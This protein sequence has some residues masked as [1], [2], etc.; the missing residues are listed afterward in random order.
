TTPCGRRGPAQPGP[1]SGSRP[2]RPAG[3]RGWRSASCRPSRA[4]LG[5]A[6]V[7]ALDLDPG[8]D[9]GGRAVA[10][11][12]KPETRPASPSLVGQGV[13]LALLLRKLDEGPLEAAK[14]IHALDGTQHAFGQGGVAQ[15]ADER[16]HVVAGTSPRPL[17]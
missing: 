8:G 4:L 14:R 9:R 17:G 10:G 6:G 13:P 12:S 16:L 7:A 11:G 1:S 2:I 5:P 3:P 15:P